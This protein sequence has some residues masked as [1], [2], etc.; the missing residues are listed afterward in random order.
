MKKVANRPMADRMR[1]IAQ[2]GAAGVHK[3]QN[4]R[5]DPKAARRRTRQ[6]ERRG[7]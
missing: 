5:R 7:E 4:R 2:S 3:D 1:S 6:E